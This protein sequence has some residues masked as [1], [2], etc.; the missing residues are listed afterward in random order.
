LRPKA[1]I[2]AA[3]PA[4]H[5]GAVIDYFLPHPVRRWALPRQSTR[6]RRLPM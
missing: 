6:R 3:A 2:L 1:L 4:W 5:A